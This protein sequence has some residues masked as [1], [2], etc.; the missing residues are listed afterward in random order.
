MNLG[1]LKNST[2]YAIELLLDK[3]QV[4]RYNETNLT[5]KGSREAC[6][7]RQKKDQRTESS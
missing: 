3:G 5:F 6:K 7:E 4:E 2:A 1:V